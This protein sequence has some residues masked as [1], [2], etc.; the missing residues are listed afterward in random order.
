VQ[1]NVEIL[2]DKEIIKAL[3]SLDSYNA[4]HGIKRG[5]RKTAKK[6]PPRISK[7]T[8][9]H[10][11]LSAKRIK[12]DIYMRSLS[13][14]WVWNVSTSSD[15]MTVKNFKLKVKKTGLEFSIYKGEKSF[16]KSAFM[17]V[18]TRTGVELPFKRI[19]TKR[20]PLRVLHGPSLAAIFHGNS[21]YGTNVVAKVREDLSGELFKE[22]KKAL[23][24]II[25][26]YGTFKV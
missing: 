15:P 21:K 3:A 12:T 16:V 10:Y 9:Q 18:N 24:E 11:N 20:Y 22:V 25:N 13:S 7:Y 5:I 17:N 4:Q 19:T 8:R 2:N 23:K 14:G 1:I 6:A 26:G